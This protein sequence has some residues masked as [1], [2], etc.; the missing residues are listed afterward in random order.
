MNQK[1][2]TAFTL[3]FC[4]ACTL[5]L[6]TDLVFPYLMRLIKAF[7][8]IG[9]IGM[10]W[11]A[12]L[13]IQRY[14]KS[15]NRLKK[16]TVYNLLF[17]SGIKSFLVNLLTVYRILIAPVLLI[18][19]FKEIPAFK[20]VLLS[21]F[22]TDALDGF[23]ARHWKVATKLGAR[24]DSLADDI[25]F[26]VALMGVI[27]MQFAFLDSHF[28]I[29]WSMLLIFTIKIVI[30]WLKHYRIISGLHTYLGKGAAFLQALFFLHCV[31]F[32]PSN[33]IFYLTA[34]VTIIAIVEEIIIILACRDL[35][36]NVKGL[37]FIKSQM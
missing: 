9:I 4:T 28:F 29:I 12:I 18:L 25:L 21:A 34:I 36:P 7:F 13:D 37:F 2:R 20:W 31:F 8:I 35:K 23:L 15:Y 30:L 22:I 1:L 33:F 3:L 6:I 24:L 16:E 10:T 5:C 27:Y 11:T 26:I 14:L 17:R 32:Q 19:L